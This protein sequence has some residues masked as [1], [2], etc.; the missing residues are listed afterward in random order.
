MLFCSKEFALFLGLVFAAYWLLPLRWA[1]AGL[2]A[3]AGAY[4]V[5][6]VCKGLAALCR[7]GWP[8][9]AA[10]LSAAVGAAWP[11]PILFWTCGV[12]CA[13]AVIAFWKGHDRGRVWLLLLASFYF[14]AS[15]NHWLAGLIC[16]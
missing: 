3:A 8:P 14:Y 11:L 13:A 7:G 4:F 6:V 5:Y 10:A 1:R 15:W 9:D 12:V 2:L 16:L